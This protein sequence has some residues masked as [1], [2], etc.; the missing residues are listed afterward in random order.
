MNTSILELQNNLTN[1]IDELRRA[2][3]DFDFKTKDGLSL[4]DLD[5][6]QAL[7]FSPWRIT[8]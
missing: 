5:E 6:V 4:S 3:D 2:F 7:S 8:R 1:L